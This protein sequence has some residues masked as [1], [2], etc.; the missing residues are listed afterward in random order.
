MSRGPEH[1][2]DVD[3]IAHVFVDELAERCDIG[4]DDGRHLRQVR[5]LQVGER[6]T[7]ADGT[8]T[9]RCY[10]IVETGR[11][12]LRLEARG[13]PHHDDAPA[14]TISLAIAPVKGGLDA[15]VA[16]VTE[17]GAARITPVRT[18]RTVV[19]WDAAKASHAVTRLRTIA[20]EAAM[21]SRRTR[22]PAVDDLVDL[23][24]VAGRQGLVVADRTGRRAFELVPPAF[25]EWTVVVGPEG[26]LAP[27]ELER[28]SAPLLALAT[29]V[30]RAGT[31]PVAAVAVLADRIA[32][33]GRA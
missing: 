23:D 7:A 20:R 15:V 11:S 13:A 25:G 26:G 12:A 17:L 18:L 31:A 24:A 30:L 2:A 22:I 16:A 9:W 8:G 10:E 14:V 1:P 21:Q 6:V 32:Q 27:S 19:R 5:R 3:A 29:S 33:M 4:G 28:L